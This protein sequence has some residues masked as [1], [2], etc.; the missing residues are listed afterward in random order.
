[1]EAVNEMTWA[2]I[3]DKANENEKL[4]SVGGGAAWYWACGLMYCRR[5]ESERRQRGERVDFIPTNQAL[6]LF[7]DPKARAHVAKLVTAKLWHKVDGGYSVNDYRKVYGGP[8]PAEPIQPAGPADIQPT[9]S[10]L[11]G[12]ARAAAASRGPAGT[13]QPKAS[14]LDQP[15]QPHARQD[16]DPKPEDPKEYNNNQD[17][18]GSS[19]GE[20]GGSRS[21]REIEIPCPTDLTLLPAQNGQLITSMI[22]QWGIDE[23]TVRFRTSNLAAPDDKRTLTVWRK[24]LARAISGGWNNTS[25]RPRMPQPEIETGDETGGYGNA[26]EWQ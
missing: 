13:F 14:R 1:M 8:A 3:D 7:P 16:P 9:P 11:G 18:T 19:A 24:C 17:L 6:V 2:F 25:T 21:G 10:Q 23:L 15:S 26:S 4:Q 22:P 5:K 12:K 20:F